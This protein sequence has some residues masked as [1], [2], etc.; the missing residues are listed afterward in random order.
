M[1]EFAL[2]LGRST[3]DGHGMASLVSALSECHEETLSDYLGALETIDARFGEALRRTE[4]ALAALAS[5]HRIEGIAAA[6]TSQ[7]ANA[8]DEAQ[9]EE[10]TRRGRSFASAS[11]LRLS[12]ALSSALGA[13][14]TSALAGEEAIHAATTDSGGVSSLPP[15]PSFEGLRRVCLDTL[16]KRRDALLMDV[17]ALLA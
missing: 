15:H 4:R 1:T 10:G 5:L 13:D 8:G 3:I 16:G 17:A 2:S 12:A 11:A 6:P 7:P 9:Q 14:H